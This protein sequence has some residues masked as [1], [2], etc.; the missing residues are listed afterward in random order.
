MFA[1]SIESLYINS[2][3]FPVHHSYF[4]LLSFISASQHLNLHGKGPS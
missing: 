3:S 1:Y 2:V 4:A